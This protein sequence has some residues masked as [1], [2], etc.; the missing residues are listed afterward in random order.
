MSVLTS[1]SLSK[2]YSSLGKKVTLRYGQIINFSI[3]TA[4]C[5]ATSASLIFLNKDNSYFMYGVSPFIGI[6]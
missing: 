4:L 5:L 3:G 2:L 1:A 6:A